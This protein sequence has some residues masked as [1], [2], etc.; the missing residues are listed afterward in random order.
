MNDIKIDG[1][2]HVIINHINITETL[3]QIAG[4]NDWPSRSRVERLACKILTALDPGELRN[5]VV[6]IESI[7]T[8]GTGGAGGGGGGEEWV[9]TLAVDR[10]VSTKT[11]YASAE[12]I[13]RL[14]T[15][16][17]ELKIAA[18]RVVEE[19][20]ER[21]LTWPIPSSIDDLAPLCLEDTKYV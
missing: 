6:K 9:G 2:G 18:R 3:Y 15:E 14:R 20:E 10:G 21:E 16:L 8:V 5:A 19:A 17:A 1:N 4:Y 7:R 11:D 12:E 13:I